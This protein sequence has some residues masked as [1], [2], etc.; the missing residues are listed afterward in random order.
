MPGRCRNRF[1]KSVTRYT[2]ADETQVTDKLTVKH[3]NGRQTATPGGHVLRYIDI[4]FAIGLTAGLAGCRQ[5][6]QDQ[7]KFV[8]L[9]GTTFFADSRSA[10]SQVAGTVARGQERSGTYFLTGMIGGKEGDGLPFPVTMTVLERGQERF[11]IYCSPCHSRVGNGEGRIVQRG[12]HQAANF[13]SERLQEA[14][15]GHFFNVITHGYGAMPDYHVELTP[16]DRWAVVA[17]IR[18]LQLSQNAKTEDAAPGTHIVSLIQVANQEGLPAAFAEED[19]IHRESQSPAPAA[20]QPTTA[21]A[22]GTTVALSFP[23]PGSQEGETSQRGSKSEEN[24]P[25]FE[26]T[27]AGSDRSPAAAPAE[28]AGD[29]AAGKQVYITN[30]QVCHQA[31]RRGL[32][33]VFP[34]L[35]GVVDK[36][37]VAHTRLTIMNGVPAATVPMPS[38]A[39]KLSATDIDNLIAFLKTKP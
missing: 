38:F 17:Y 21:P 25:G 35:A 23:S 30:C 2:I 33:P 3:I 1:K 14:P 29:S 18:A 22:M 24:L 6:M 39:G 13:H 5:D 4:L 10:R 28:T 27:P 9:R 34:S 15:A 7:P 26:G 32:A 20:S 11:N 37:G 36:A 19:W 31:D 16:V 8:P 12:Y